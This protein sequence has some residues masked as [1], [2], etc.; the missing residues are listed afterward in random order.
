MMDGSGGGNA[1]MNSFSRTWQFLNDPRSTPWIIA[2]L[3]M[4]L[5]A[6]LLVI[7]WLAAHDFNER[8]EQLKPEA[9]QNCVDQL[10]RLQPDIGAKYLA[11]TCAPDGSLKVLAWEAPGDL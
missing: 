5:A 11:V 9:F 7:L 2:Y 3:F 1:S 8:V 6:A 10:E 4:A